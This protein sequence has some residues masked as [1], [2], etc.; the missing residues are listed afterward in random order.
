MNTDTSK[1][2]FPEATLVLKPHLDHLP[3]TRIYDHINLISKKCVTEGQEFSLSMSPRNVSMPASILVN[4]RVIYFPIS[5]KVR[6]LSTKS[7]RLFSNAI[8]YL[9]SDIGGTNGYWYYHRTHFSSQYE[10][11][12]Y[13]LYAGNSKITRLGSDEDVEVIPQNDFD[14]VTF[15]SKFWKQLFAIIQDSIKNRKKVLKKLGILE[16]QCIYREDKKREDFVMPPS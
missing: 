8:M 16:A 6:H 5:D 15:R 1:F 4:D 12:V 10:G 14:L 11:N 13:S 7:A 2:S 9:R 3:F